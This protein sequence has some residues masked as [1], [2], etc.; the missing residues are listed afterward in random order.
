MGIKVGDAV[1]HVDGLFQG[2]PA[3]VLEVITDSAQIRKSLPLY[4]AEGGEVVYRIQFAQEVWWDN[5]N[6]EGNPAMGIWARA[7][8]WEVHGDQ[9]RIVDSKTTHSTKPTLRSE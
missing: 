5:G 6:P 8:V 9:W 3:R 2:L 1:E 7:K 4:A